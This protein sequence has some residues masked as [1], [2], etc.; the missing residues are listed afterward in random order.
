MGSLAYRI[1]LG[2]IFV[3]GPPFAAARRL[4]NIY[5][6]S[7]NTM[8]DLSTDRH[9]LTVEIGDQVS[10]VCPEPG[11]HYEFTQLY[12]VSHEEYNNCYLVTD[13]KPKLIGACTEDDRQSSLSIV[14]RKYSPLP[15]GLE[16]MPGHNYY[17]IST[18]NGTRETLE[19][20]KGGLCERANMKAK[21]EVQPDH[22]H[23]STR[24]EERSS[25]NPKFQHAARMTVVDHE[26]ES[27]IASE[28]SMDGSRVTYTIQE[29]T[30]EG[31][32]DDAS[33][34]LSLLP[35]VLLL[36]IGYL[37]RQ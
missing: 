27:T 34:S 9:V 28:I 23:K 1:L 30:E 35:I 37:L 8:F 18:S 14:F 24:H 5:W 12:L 4:P 21:F 20:R 22:H 31:G 13:L 3:V 15:G 26:S 25:A 7:S 10:I 36:T 11:A 19:N 16:F 33:S 17:V 29:R 32:D 6:N 2:A